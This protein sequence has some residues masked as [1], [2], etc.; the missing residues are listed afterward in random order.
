MEVCQ[1]A[2]QRADIPDS[3]HQIADHADFLWLFLCGDK[4]CH[5]QK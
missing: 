2:E 1:Q 5:I 4:E 3:K